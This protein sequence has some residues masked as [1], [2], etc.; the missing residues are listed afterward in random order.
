MWF[1]SIKNKWKSYGARSGNHGEEV[2]NSKLHCETSKLSMCELNS[3]NG[4]QIY[5]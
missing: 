5:S 3:R 4:V 2:T 1:P